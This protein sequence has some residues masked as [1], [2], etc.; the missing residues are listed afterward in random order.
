MEKRLKLMQVNVHNSRDK[1]ASMTMPTKYKTAENRYKEKNNSLHNPSSIYSKAM[2]LIS[3]KSM[4]KSSMI[5]ED[6]DE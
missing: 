5:T 2:Q 1:P 6:A 4:D 3:R